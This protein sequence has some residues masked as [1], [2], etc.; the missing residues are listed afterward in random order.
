M[1]KQATYQRLLGILRILASLR[2]HLSVVEAT[3]RVLETEVDHVAD[4]PTIPILVHDIR[5]KSQNL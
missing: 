1:S 4:R 2:Y 3:G 5:V